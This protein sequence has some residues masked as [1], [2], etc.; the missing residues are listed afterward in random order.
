MLDQMMIVAADQSTKAYQLLEGVSQNV[1]NANTFGYKATR[2][3]Q[4][5]RPDGNVDLV[6]RTD[7]SPG[8]TFLTRRE[9]DVALEGPGFIQVTRPDGSTGYT[10]NGSFTRNAEG[11]LVTPHG[12]LVGTGIQMPAVYHKVRILNDGRVQ[13]VEKPGAQP[14]EIGHLTVV[15]FKNP[16]GLKN[17]GH[18]VVMETPESG[19]AFKVENHHLISQGKLEQSNV[20]IH[21]AVEDILRLNAGV[22]SNLRIVKAVDEIYREAVQLRQ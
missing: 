3:E 10:R 16:E 13:L 5:I 21:H 15:N 12:D 22:I 18:H 8:P 4:Y 7:Y 19:P 9:L 14:K 20:N 11:F 6:Q 2:F 1:G 17:V